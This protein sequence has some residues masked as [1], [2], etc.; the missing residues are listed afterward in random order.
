MSALNERVSELRDGGSYGDGPFSGGPF[1]LNERVSE[2]RDGGSYG[3]GP[4]SGGPFSG[5]PDP[6]TDPF[7]YTTFI[8][9]SEMWIKIGAPFFHNCRSNG[10][11]IASEFTRLNQNS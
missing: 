1:A 2:L 8:N 7:A 11:S 4:F 6:V 5:G 9:F 3:D 10:Q